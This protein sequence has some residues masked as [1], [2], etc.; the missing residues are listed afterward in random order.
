MSFFD[1][2]SWDDPF[3]DL[4]DKGKSV[5]DKATDIARDAIGVAEILGDSIV[6]AAETV[7]DG[8]VTAGE[9]VAKWSVTATGEA[10][11]W[12]KTSYA[13]VAE[14]SENA[15]GDV[16]GFS[17][18]AFNEARNALEVGAAWVW[19]QIAAYFYET[20]PE[21]GGLDPRAREAASYLLSEPVARGMESLCA[22][23]GCVISFGIKLKALSSV[24][25]GLYVCGGGWGFFV[26]SRFDSLEAM[27][28]NPSL[29]LG[30]SA[31]VTMVFGPVSRASRARAIKL[32]LG[33]KSHPKAKLAATI[34]GVILMEASMPPLFLGIRYMMD[35]DLDLF[36][37][38]KTPDEARKL[39]WKVSAAAPKPN[40]EF[41]TAAYG[42]AELGWQELT[43]GISAQAPNFDAAARA[44]ADP[45]S[46]DRIQA[47]ALAS[48]MS[49]FAAR[50]Y[51]L[52]RASRGQTVVGTHQGALGLDL[53]G[54]RK[55]VQ[56]VMG[57]TD[58]AGVSFEAVGE[59]PLYWCA[60]VDGTVRLVPYDRSL[61]LTGTTFRML[62]GLTGQGASF[63]VAADGKD[64]PRFLVATRVRGGI[65]TPTPVFCAERLVGTEA[66]T[67]EDAT[68]LLDRP[69]DP[70][71][72]ATPLLRPG[73]FLRVGESKR[74][75]NGMFSLLLADNG[76]L[77][78]RR[79]SSGPLNAPTAWLVYQPGM[80][81]D[82]ATL[83][84][85]ASPQPPAAPAYHAIVTDDGRLAVRAGADPT[86]AG[87]TLWQSDRIGEPGPCF[88][89]VT[90][91]GVV[92]LMRGAPDAPGETVWSSAGGAVHWPLRRQLV[93]LKASTGYVSAGNGGGVSVPGALTPAPAE[94]LNAIGQGVAGW[95]TFELQELCDGTIALRAQG[96]RYVCVTE[97]GPYLICYR[98][99]VGPHELFTREVVSGGNGQPTRIRLK[100][101]KTGKY[102][103]AAALP[104]MSASAEVDAAALLDLI[105][106]DLNL[107][108][109]TGR[110]VHIVARHSGKAL[111]VPG[112]RPD[113]GLGLV[114]G[115]FHAG[116]NQKWILTE[117]GGGWFSL[118]NRHTNKCADIIGSQ[119][120]VGA[121]ALQWPAHGGANQSFHLLPQGDGTYAIIA[122]HSGQRLEVSGASAELGAPVVQAPPGPGAHQRWV[123]TLATAAKKAPDAFESVLVGDL[124]QL[125][126]LELVRLRSWKGDYLRRF[127]QGDGVTSDAT[128]DAWRVVR[129]GTK[130]AL[131]SARGDYL[132]RPD[133]PQGVT[134]WSLTGGSE[135]TLELRGSRV[136]LRSWKGDY[137]HRPDSP[138]GVTTWGATIGSEWTFEALVP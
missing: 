64:N 96:R 88:M 75:A 86:Q 3:V 16:A 74:S 69:L 22:A 59:P 4:Y 120:T 87:A 110:L 78:M 37:K 124:D 129:S 9:G 82:E 108:A 84:A 6:D 103:A 33:L 132:H 50:Y 85:W 123:I 48:S 61:D 135:W 77:V 65:V 101:V 98:D 41:A 117:M 5:V 25:V 97:G 100:S 105:E 51:G 92:T 81:Q 56:L 18:A 106:F 14:W 66:P 93:A 134:T 95:E 11:D 111:E 8:L 115:R 47:T 31:Y 36:G 38:Q 44:Q 42:L 122:R 83:W 125:L 107:S 10:I 72:A 21:L 119:T 45:A 94:W 90:N 55:T 63:A 76:R 60:G 53:A 52:V 99:E 121:I 13:E 133:S 102:I 26:D 127:I 104:A 58:P 35:L 30:V 68:F 32:G 131:R 137:L 46:A 80:I 89:A 19:E 126:K 67:R 70:P 91:Q 62:R 15:A 20:L 71:E 7:G 112:G 28:A 54:D 27:L 24:N 114:Q 113:D 34:G 12:S 138:S 23:A 79:R 17:V 109:H 130:L 40:G 57:L 43:A 29:S 1:P 128:G 118:T 73:Q 2:S 116:D 39:K 136:L 49:P